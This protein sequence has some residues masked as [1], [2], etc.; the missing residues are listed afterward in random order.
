MRRSRRAA[1]PGSDLNIDENAVEASVTGKAAAHAAALLGN[2]RVREAIPEERRVATAIVEPANNSELAELIKMCEA[3]QI[4]L[5]PIGAMRTLLQIRRAPVAL[6]VSLRHL[7]RIIAHEPDD[8]TV[9]TEA[10][11]TV[12]ALNAVLGRS[13]QRLP[14]DP[15]QPD[16]TTIAALI[17]AG[18]AGPLR[19][20]EGT[21]RDLLI[22]IEFVGHGGRAIHSGGR[23]VK[24][25]AGYDL[26]KVMGGSFGTLGVIKQ[27]AF[28]VR[29]IPEEYAVGIVAHN[30]A[31][32]AF[33]CAARLLDVLPLS[34]LEVLSPAFAS[35]FGAPGQF[36]VVAGFSGNAAEIGYQAQKILEVANDRGA[37]FD[38]DEAAAHYAT[39]RDLDFGGRA[40]SGR[41]A[42]MPA[43]LPAALDTIAG[44]F[45]AH[46]GNGVAEI[47]IN[48]EQS[49]ESA[50]KIVAEWRQRAHRARGH[51]NLIAAAEP[52]RDALKFFDMP[53]DGA[54]KAMRR[55]K[56]AFDPAGI[57]N[58]GCFVGDI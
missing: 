19:L 16:V 13:K 5:A 10:G 21:A 37:I 20:S 6:G 42:V 9:I 14:V 41:L 32:D 39:L 29:P 33:A 18:R 48:A 57:F 1:P 50:R 22:G 11:I 51:L 12:G 2:D 54:L 45:C 15:C 38:D 53:N 3:E 49:V 36:A 52:I 35:R 28:K 43:E 47:A 40:L 25:V 30:R 7:N 56:Q 58:P 24:N 44:E 27:A 34:H 31:D 55:L 23:V 8:L 17:A 46:A 4:L 26:M